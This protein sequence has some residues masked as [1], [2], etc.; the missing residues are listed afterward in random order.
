MQKRCAVA[1]CKS[2]HDAALHRFPKDPR[3]RKLWIT[4]CRRSE[5]FDPN[6]SLICSNHF[7]AEDFERDLRNE[8]LNLPPRRMLKQGSRPTLNL[9]NSSSQI[10][11]APEP[12]DREERS[13]KKQR[14][15]LVQAAIEWVI[16]STLNV[17][18]LDVRQFPDTMQIS[19]SSDSMYNSLRSCCTA[20]CIY[21]KIFY[22]NTKLT[23][24]MLFCTF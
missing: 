10:K 15:E 18:H 23:I 19:C 22:T 1:N 11:R 12:S 9:S 6:K 8:L 3:L 5:N 14:K 13:A 20:H 16:H 2:A 21:K 24:T 7:Q 4:S 17:K